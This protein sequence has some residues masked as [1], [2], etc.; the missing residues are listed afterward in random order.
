VD[1]VLR[2]GNA[3]GFYGDRF[4]AFR[5]MLEGGD[6]GVLTGDY[7]AELTM[8]IL[9]RQ[10]LQDTTRGYAGTFLRQ[11]EDCLGIALE[12]AVTIVTNAGGLNPAGLAAA[13]KDLAS[14]LGL[15]ARVAWV[16]GDDVTARAAELGLGNP[17]AANAYLGAWGIAA[18][19]RS[20]ADVVVTGRV[21]DASLV[22][23]PAAAHF[24]WER[25]NWDALAGATVAGHI[26]ECGAQATGGNYSFFTEHDMRRPGFP[27][28]EVH[29]DGSCVITKHP[30]T[31][32]AVTIETVT[33]QLLYEIDAPRYLGPD[34]VARFDTVQLADDGPDR[35]RVTGVRGAPPPPTLK[36]CCNTLSGYRNAVVFVLCGRDIDA[37]AA[38]VRE[39]M[40]LAV[41]AASPEEIRWTLARTDHPDA[42]DEEAASALLHCQVRDAD[43][44]LVGRAFSAHAV[45]IGLS[46]YPGFH[47]TAPPGDASPVGLYH[48][49]LIPADAVEHVAVLD[50]GSRVAIPPPT[51]TAA[52]AQL[53]PEAAS[54][55][56]PAHGGPT[57]RVALGSIVGARSGDKGGNANLG[58][59]A[60][61]DKAWPWLA[62]TLTIGELQRLLPETAAYTIHRYVLANLRALNFVIEGLLGEGVA[63]STRF[64]PQA[65]ALGEWLRSRTIDIPEELL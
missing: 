45:G 3:S 34:V 65:K 27:I 24:D 2:I 40:E 61:D 30:G 31:G 50:D 7:L 35:V 8:L 48:P 33:A 49:G 6:L 13:L 52:S 39:Q 20:G 41:G 63:S 38:L 46:S 51:E 42:D 4:A 25:N 10:R 43:P 62:H 14:R 15:Q 5:E 56:A 55:P 54:V 26:L 29:A 12:R 44:A 19:I 37:K 53:A 21:T 17:L 59:W 36:V 47:L 22:V 11:M 58:V 28:A 57:R 18:C 16:D 23:G 64:D 60:R 9:G 32:G 1:T